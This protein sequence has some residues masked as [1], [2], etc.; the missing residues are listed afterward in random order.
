MKDL[1]QR[2]QLSVD[3]CK[4]LDDEFIQSNQRS[5]GEE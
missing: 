4:K 3:T 2:K 1:T 5:G